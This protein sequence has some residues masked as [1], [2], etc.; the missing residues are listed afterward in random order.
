[1]ALHGGQRTSGFLQRISRFLQRTGGLAEGL[2]ICSIRPVVSQK[3]LTVFRK[4]L[5]VSS[6]PLGLLSKIPSVPSPP[7]AFFSEDKPA[8]ALCLRCRPAQPWRGRP[9]RYLPRAIGQRRI[10]PLSTRR[11]AVE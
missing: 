8:A 2:I 3:P 1:M 10:F 7:E 9:P 6:R 11:C 5:V 4:I